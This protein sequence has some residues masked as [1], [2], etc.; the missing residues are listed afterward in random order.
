M[1]RAEPADPYA[2]VAENQ[3]RHGLGPIDMARFIQRRVEAGE[4]NATI[5]RRLV[6]NLTTVAHHLTL[7]DLPPELD[8]ALQSGRCT[9]PRT[10]HELKRLHANQPA[11]VEALMGGAK[12]ISR[13]A[14]AALK[15]E[16]HDPSHAPSSSPASGPLVA[17]AL[18]ACDRL[19]A[20]LARI[21][22]PASDAACP[23]NLAELKRRIDG[24]PE[25]WLRGSDRQTPSQAER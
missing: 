16:R 5:A 9:S 8:K 25:R 2:Q 13:E 7:L 24:L 23:P 4:S 6:M 18:A 11:Q 21:Q 17:K 15:A 14:V 19:E 22:P 10:L 1:V 3:K 12:P 20:T